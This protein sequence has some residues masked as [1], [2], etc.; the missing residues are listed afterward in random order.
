MPQL[1]APLCTQAA[2]FVAAC[3]P[4][5][6]AG[7]CRPACAE[8]LLPF[9]LECFH[10]VLRQ[11]LFADQQGAGLPSNEQLSAVYAACFPPWSVLAPAA[12]PA[13]A[14]MWVHAAAADA[15]AAAG[16]AA[17]PGLDAAALQRPGS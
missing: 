5:I 11:A 8:E 3:L 2:P 4:G 14:P 1:G 13:Q 17:A 7:T 10:G 15:A 12:A 9:N 6:A 16:A